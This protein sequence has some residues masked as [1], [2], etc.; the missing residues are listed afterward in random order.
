MTETKKI[1]RVIDF[2]INDI[3]TEE[4]LKKVISPVP[5]RNW[6]KILWFFKHAEIGPIAMYRLKDPVTGKVY[7][8]CNVCYEKDGYKRGSA[9]PYLFEKYN[10]R[11]NEEFIAKFD[12]DMKTYVLPGDA[13][14]LLRSLKLF[15][16]NYRIIFHDETYSFDTTDIQELMLD[17]FDLTMMTG[18][19]KQYNLTDYGWK[20]DSLYYDLLQAEPLER[21]EKVRL[22]VESIIWS[23]D[24]RAKNVFCTDGQVFTGIILSKE[25][26][27]DS[28]FGE[29]GISLVTEEGQYV[30][31]P[32]SKILSIEPK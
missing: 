29:S 1:K 10:I 6:R 2:N 3:K 13:Y 27:E 20:L 24:G 22:T 8:P 21:I 9:V 26:K 31:L 11:L 4:D 32:L 12:N 25:D 30:E 7:A 5:I 15:K 18:M 28:G 17:V 16:E 23:N 19:D 14:L